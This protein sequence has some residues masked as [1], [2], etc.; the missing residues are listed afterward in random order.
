MFGNKDKELRIE[1]L[2]KKVDSGEVTIASLRRELDTIE[3]EHSERVAKIVRGQASE[4]ERVQFAHDEEIAR[5][6]RTY[7]ST[8]ERKDAAYLK[9]SDQ[10]NGELE[11]LE[12][13]KSEKL[14]AESDAREARTACR[15]AQDEL[16]GL[17][18]KRKME[19]ECLEHHM[20]IQLESGE[21]AL[22]KKA[23]KLK[24]TAAA[25]VQA[26]KDEASE[27]IAT[28]KDEYNDKLA[29]SLT[30]RTADS[31]ETMKHILDRLPKVN[32]NAMVGGHAPEY[33]DA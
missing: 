31:A 1:A 32:V 6:H 2:R 14:Q 22:Q 18:I 13:L 29:E 30:Q 3:D 27:Q 28:I 26:A 19:E 24:E 17:K 8:I 15:E 4:R 23:L 20:V 16:E 11:E 9:L 7:E 12:T 33:E 10:V 25:E 5:I 21:I